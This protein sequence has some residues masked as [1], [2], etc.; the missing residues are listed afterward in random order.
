M[1]NEQMTLGEGVTEPQPITLLSIDRQ[2]SEA[3]PIDLTGATLL[4]MRVRSSVEDST[5]FG[6]DTT[7]DPSNLAF[8]VDRTT[9]IVT[10]TPTGTEFSFEDLFYECYFM[11]TDASGAEIRIPSDGFIAIEVIEAF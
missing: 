9:G 10:F 5:P 1:P 6:Y 3:T 7:N 11:L 8:P 4:E 2:T